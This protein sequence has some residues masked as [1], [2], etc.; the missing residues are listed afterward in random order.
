MGLD[1][2]LTAKRYIWTYREN[3]KKIKVVG[4]V[5]P[6]GYELKEISVRAAY[7]RKVNAIHKWFVENVQEG[8]D[9]CG[10]YLVETEKLKELL[11]IVTEV[12]ANKDNAGANLPTAGGFFF[13]GTE[14]DEWYWEGL[15][16]T[17]EQ[18]TKLLKD[19][20]D[21]WEFYYQ[22]SW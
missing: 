7:W 16:Y 18:L 3:D 9:D 22:S 4:L 14:Y 1:Q 11:A 5:M 2:Y 12:L 21:N 19:F 17:K 13:G 15:E 20:D 8:E 6:K 10:E